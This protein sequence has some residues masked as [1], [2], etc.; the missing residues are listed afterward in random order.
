MIYTEA[1]E[2][3]R[4]EGWFGTITLW[5]NGGQ[6]QSYAELNIRDDGANISVKPSESELDNAYTRWQ[7]AQDIRDSAS[8]SQRVTRDDILRLFRTEMISANPDW[9]NLYITVKTFVEANPRLLQAVTN[10]IQWDE[11]ADGYTLYTDTLAGKAKW[12]RLVFDLLP[13]FVV[14]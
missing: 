8:E 14:S 9:A 5:H 6:A 4:D 11:I 7:M 3:L 1:I 12:L 2:Q 10:R 13:L